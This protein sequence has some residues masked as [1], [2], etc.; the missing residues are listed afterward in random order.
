MRKPNHSVSKG[1]IAG[2]LG[3]LA[4]AWTMNQ[5]QRIVMATKP[6]AEQEEKRESEDATMKVA[7]AVAKPFLQRDLTKEEKQ[8]AGPVV[9]YAYGAAI[10]GLYGGAAT[11]DRGT[12]AGFGAAYGT[13]AF[14]L[15]DEVAL[16]ALGLSGNPLDYPVSSHAEALASHLVYGLTLEAVRRLSVKLL[17]A[18]V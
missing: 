3:G 15:G 7:Q 5:F 8:K 2:I 14:V 17:N 6:L 4:G 1:I 10:G 18:V 12:T 9:H 16:P 11:E 13:A